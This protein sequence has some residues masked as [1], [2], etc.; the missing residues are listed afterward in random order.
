MYNDFTVVFQGPLHMLLLESIPLYKKFVDKIYISCWD[1]DDPTLTSKIE[2]AFQDDKNIK[3]VKSTLPN[4]DLVKK[5]QKDQSAHYYYQIFSTLKGLEMVD[6][7]YTIKLRTDEIYSNLKPILDGI[8][9]NK[10]MIVTSNIMTL[11]PI[12]SDHVFG[13][14]TKDLHKSFS[15][16]SSELNSENGPKISIVD[17]V[18][19]EKTFTNM[20]LHVLKSK[21]QITNK[22]SLTKSFS[23]KLFKHIK[24]IDLNELG[25]YKIRWNTMGKTFTNLNLCPAE[26]CGYIDLSV[27]SNN[28]IEHNY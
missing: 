14:L 4:L 11:P 22:T 19:I 7:K 28:H 17:G 21:T 24:F 18:S 9:E 5:W 26:N 23:K 20:F 13:G 10:N 3:F 16:L 2:S 25:E 1:D 12:I 6:T 15:I 27:L 8:L